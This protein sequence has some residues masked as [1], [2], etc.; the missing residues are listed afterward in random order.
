MPVHYASNFSGIKKIY[1][2]ADKYKIRVVED[3]AHSFGGTSNQGLV[4][5]F[6]DIVCFSFDGI[7]NITSGEGGAIVT[8]DKDIY[9]KIKDIRLLGVVKDTEKRYAGERSWDFDVVDQ[10]WR[11]HMSNIMAS[12]G[13]VQLTR[14]DNFQSSN[15]YYSKNN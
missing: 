5:S 8:K 6:G 1:E 3:A 9:E 14:L 13:R 2:I 15:N 12:I 7:K 11:Y 10:G 4:G